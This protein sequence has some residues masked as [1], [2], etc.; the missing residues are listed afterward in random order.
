M[1]A[2]A[3][4]LDLQISDLTMIFPLTLCFLSG[5]VG[6]T[7]KSFL[8]EYLFPILKWD[9][10]NLLPCNKVVRSWENGVIE[11]FMVNQ[12]KMPSLSECFKFLFRE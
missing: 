2:V 8:I 12:G 11:A 6:E 1:L 7:Q 9:L 4:H 3:A 10:I 5:K